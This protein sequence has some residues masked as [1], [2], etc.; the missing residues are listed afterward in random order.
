MPGFQ[1][2]LATSRHRFP[3]PKRLATLIDALSNG[4]SGSGSGV[5][6]G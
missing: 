5:A 1:A 6:E 2:L 4:Y 3:T